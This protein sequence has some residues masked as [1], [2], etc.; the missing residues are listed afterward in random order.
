M[1]HETWCGMTPFEYWENWALR[2]QKRVQAMIMIM[3]VIGHDHDHCEK[4]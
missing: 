3:N 2:L 1:H 4:Y